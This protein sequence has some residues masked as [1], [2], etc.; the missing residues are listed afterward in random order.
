MPAS[1]GNRRSPGCVQTT[2]VAHEGVLVAVRGVAVA[3]LLT[4]AMTGCATHSGVGAV[5]TSPSA[6]IQAPSTAPVLVAP[7]SL[8]A[9]STCG[10]YGL[11][12]ETP[13]AYAYLLGCDSLVL[14]PPVT[15]DIQR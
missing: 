12:A 4:S 8:M 11:Y 10:M 5:S 6:H 7:A 3:V 1:L 2:S 15:L 13:T 14:S 9:T